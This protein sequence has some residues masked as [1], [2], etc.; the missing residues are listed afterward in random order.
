MFLEDSELCIQAHELVQLSQ[1]Q[2][3]P[4]SFVRVHR[5]V[6]THP[7]LP[8][9]SNRA[10]L[11]ILWSDFRVFLFLVVFTF[12]NAFFLFVY[13]VFLFPFFYKCAIQLEAL[14][15]EGASVALNV[16]AE[17][18]SHAPVQVNGLNP[19]KVIVDFDDSSAAE[20]QSDSAQFGILTFGADVRG[21]SHC[22]DQL[23]SR[24]GLLLD[25]AKLLVDD[26]GKLLYILLVIIVDGITFVAP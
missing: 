1:S 15:V 11:N 7:I 19:L 6:V 3:F 22:L 13:E 21:F 4:V 26:F 10:D 25:K 23:A 14:E 2:V 8:L 20:S 24:F 16:D 18:R 5:I 9:Y 12:V 17:A